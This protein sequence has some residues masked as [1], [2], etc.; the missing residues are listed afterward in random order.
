MINKLI[1]Q[2]YAPKMGASS[3]VC[4]ARGGKKNSNTFHEEC[5]HEIF[6]S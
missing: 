5:A 3:K 1:N 2:P 4:G 6:S